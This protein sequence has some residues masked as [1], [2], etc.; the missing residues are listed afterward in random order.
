MTRYQTQQ[1]KY[2]AGALSSVVSSGLAIC[3]EFCIELLLLANPLAT[4]CAARN[5]STGA[6]Q[7]SQELLS[8]DN[9]V[10]GFRGKYQTKYY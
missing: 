3:L 4:T 2:T 6:V 5:R 10:V 9:A 7:P 1:M 8:T